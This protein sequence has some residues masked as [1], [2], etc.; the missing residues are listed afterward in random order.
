M[1]K[2]LRILLPLAFLAL[3][4][5]AGWRLHQLL[6]RPPAVEVAE[7][8]TRD[9]RRVLALTG[10]IRPQ[11]R[12]QLVPAVR[13]RLLDLLAEEGAAVKRGDLLARL[14]GREIEADLRR[15][16]SSLLRAE[17]ERDQ[18]AR[19]LERVRA[20][21]RDDL[22]PI[23]ELEDATLALQQAVRRAEEEQQ[24]I[25]ELQ[26]RQDDYLLRSPLDGYVLER[27]VDPGQVVG[28]ENVIYEL[29]TIGAP[30]VEVDVDERFLAE[31]VLGQEATVAALGGR[32]QTYRTEVAYIGRRIDRSSGAAVVR[33]AFLDQA[34]D[35][36][37]GLSLDVNLEVEAHPQALTVPRAAVAGLGGRPWV[38]MV[39]GETTVR[40]EVEV[41]DWPAPDLVV[42]A[43]LAEGER[44]V[45]E[46]RR[47]P[48]GALVRPQLVAGEG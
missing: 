23:Q 1:K 22:V 28:P 25:A 20:L 10:R 36:P 29:A 14:D 11:Q 17:E 18:E 31:L 4:A 26:A 35:L 15:V 2:I 9:V 30:W 44:V 16:R 6:D 7:V 42:L 3:L 21:H 8:E 19:D 34:P 32:R 48:E 27:P 47:T 38:L 13:G 39:D 37:V 24:V 12:N 43:G 40:R 46:P 5:M 45:L 41:I 33:L